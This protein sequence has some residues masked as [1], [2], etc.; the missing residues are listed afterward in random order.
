MRLASLA[1]AA[2]VNLPAGFE[3]RDCRGPACAAWR[4]VAEEVFGPGAP[5]AAPWVMEG[6]TEVAGEVVFQGQEPVGGALRWRHA[7]LPETTGYLGALAV[8]PRWRRMGLGAALLARAVFFMA[9][10]GRQSVELDTAD[11]RVQAIRLFAAAGF[12]PM[13]ENAEE[14]RRWECALR[15][16]AEGGG[17]P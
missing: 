16:A 9:A 13:P 4:R 12:R 1:S 14:Q 11:D 3:G 15:A 7:Y 6:V 2:W 10:E 8:R 17:G 5:E